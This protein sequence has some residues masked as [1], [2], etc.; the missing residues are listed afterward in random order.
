MA[1]MNV[2]RAHKVGLEEAS[3]PEWAR[4]E[5]GSKPMGSMQKSENGPQQAQSNTS[6]ESKG[7][8]EDPSAPRMKYKVIGLR[9]PKR[10]SKGPWESWIRKWPRKPK[11]IKWAKD[12]QEEN[13]TQGP[14][15]SV[16]KGPVNTLSH[17]EGNK[18]QA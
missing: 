16:R 2:S 10:V 18:Q 9:K 4:K 5:R 6:K 15:N 13:G 8:M 12:A 3:E 17:W 14:A 7:L 11:E 1:L